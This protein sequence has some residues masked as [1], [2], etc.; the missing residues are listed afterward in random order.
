MRIRDIVHVSGPALRIGLDDS[1]EGPLVLQLSDPAKL[2]ANT[3]QLD[4]YG[5]ELLA[6]FLLTARLASPDEKIAEE[7]SDGPFGCR[8]S[9]RGNARFASIDIR[10][11]GQSLIVSNLL[12]DR[13]YA[14]LLIALAHGRHGNH[15]AFLLRRDHRTHS[16][17][18]H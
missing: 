4:L 6:G 16:R 10:Q 3:V 15:G 9:L 12:W 1:G 5:G 7:R 18:L 17:L 14:E 13:L 8:I 11:A 2:P